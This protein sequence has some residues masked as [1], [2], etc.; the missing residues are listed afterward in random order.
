MAPVTRRDR[1]AQVAISHINCSA[2]E[3]SLAY[4]DVV[5]RPED[6]TNDRIGH[7]V[8]SRMF[9]TAALFALGCLRLAGCVEPECT[10]TCMPGGAI[11]NPMADIQ[12][13]ARRFEGWMTSSPPVPAPHRGDIWVIADEEGSKHAGVCVEDA[14]LERGTWTVKTVEGGHPDERNGSTAIR[15]FDRTFIPDGARLRLGSRYLL[16]YARADAMPLPDAVA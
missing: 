1:I 16:G 2:T 9:C 5:V 12:H 6:R 3:S 8:A 11:R 15:A 7:F 14:V 13:L 4:I 10:A